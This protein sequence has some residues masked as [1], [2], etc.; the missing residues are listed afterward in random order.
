MHPCA[1]ADIVG[2]TAMSKDVPA[3]EVII[4]L[5]YL[6]SRFDNLVSHYHLQKVDTVRA[7]GI[8][9]SAGFLIL[10]A[11][12]LCQRLWGSG[13][14]LPP[15]K[16]HCALAGHAVLGS[17]HASS[18]ASQAPLQAH[19]YIC[20]LTFF[21]CP[22]IGDAFIVASGILAPDN[23]VRW[24]WPGS[25]GVGKGRGVGMPL[26]PLACTTVV[27]HG[28]A[29]VHVI[30][31]ALTDDYSLLLLVQG[32]R[33]VDDEHDPA[34]GAARVVAFAVDMLRVSQ[35][36]SACVLRLARLCGLPSIVT[37]S[38]QPACCAHASLPQ[39]LRAATDTA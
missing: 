35:P 9:G 29:C 26:P 23:E 33:A 20:S 10:V 2:F 25:V 31:L 30:V 38:A 13:L 22:Q 39:L 16:G 8:G 19:M 3:E 6:F 14:R 34:Q 27:P 12:A 28:N 21:P 17:L 11:Q 37:P 5:N 24:W 36:V 1:H 7:C 18:L 4:F 32:F 15:C